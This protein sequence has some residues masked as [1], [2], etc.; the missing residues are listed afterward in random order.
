MFF[1]LKLSDSSLTMSSN[2]NLRGNY[3][4]VALITTKEPS[5]NPSLGACAS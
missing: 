3:F 5:S 1:H 2:L 4:L